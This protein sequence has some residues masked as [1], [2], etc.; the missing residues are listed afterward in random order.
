MKKVISAF[1]IAFIS[2]LFIGTSLQFAREAVWYA[3]EEG[4]KSGVLHI[5]DIV[6]TLD[7]AYQEKLVGH[8]AFISLNGAFN[9]VTFSDAVPSVNKANSVYRLKNGYIA[10]AVNEFKEFSEAEKDSIKRARAAADE[11][12]AMALFV[13]IPPKVCDEND[14]ALKG[15]KNYEYD[16]IDYR[17][18][19]F[20]ENGFEILNLHDKL[21]E[22]NL[23]HYSL[24]YRTDHHWNADAGLW[25]STELSTYL[26]GKGFSIN[27]KTFDKENYD[28]TVIEDLFLGS[29]GKQV[30][31]YYAGTDDFKYFTPKAETDY[32]K[33]G[34]SDSLR[35]SGGF[36]DVMFEKAKLTTDLFGSFNYSS[37]LGGDFAQTKVI[38]NLNKTGPKVLI[39][40]DS[41]SNVL[42][43]YFAAECSE[44]HMIDPRH[45]K[46][47]VSDYI[48][49]NG[50]D[51][52]IISLSA[53]MTNSDFNWE[54]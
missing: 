31:K 21:H 39:I 19:F 33:T 16:V 8:D 50:F 42:C 3:R 49:S 35:N 24:F 2:F 28:E 17:I 29:Q 47:S 43:T 46:E 13:S 25:A 9:K 48:S 27:S 23:D 26:S 4:I 10:F 51:V 44:L 30:G 54:K 1:F 34:G 6:N 5:W 37:F 14:F 18:G 40:K 32:S 22:Q 52:V 38:N 36:E 15:V 20:E 12:G 53:R 41:F 11:T 45:Y 7:T